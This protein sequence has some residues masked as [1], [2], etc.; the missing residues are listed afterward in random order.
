MLGNIQLYF[1]CTSSIPWRERPRF[2][3][4]EAVKQNIR[5][6]WFESH[7]RG[8]ATTKQKQ[9]QWNRFVQNSSG[10]WSTLAVS[11]TLCGHWWQ[12]LAW[13]KG[14]KFSFL[15]KLA[16]CLESRP[17]RWNQLNRHL[18]LLI[19]SQ[20]RMEQCY[21]HPGPGMLVLWTQ[22]LWII[23]GKSWFERSESDVLPVNGAPYQNCSLSVVVFMILWWAVGFSGQC[24]TP[25]RRPC[26]TVTSQCSCVRESTCVW[27]TKN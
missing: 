5:G 4:A 6:L 25:S 23:K 3:Q 15:T 9:P 1:R 10:C 12:T 16:T 22:N 18:T 19:V 8:W 7:Q 27:I 20:P 14:Y 13:P 2:S 17:G 24:L 26:C 11:A 21:L